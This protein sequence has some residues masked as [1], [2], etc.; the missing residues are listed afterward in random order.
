MPRK[1][2]ERPAILIELKKDLSANAAIE[3]IHR[4]EH[5]GK[6]AEY[7]GQVIL[8]GINYDSKTKTHSCKIEHI[9]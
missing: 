7:D 6:V 2:V 5:K 1:G 8:V 4:K 3:Q 9:T